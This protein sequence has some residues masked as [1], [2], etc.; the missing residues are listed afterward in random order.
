M[1]QINQVTHSDANNSNFRRDVAL[2]ITAGVLFMQTCSYS[3][4]W[5][6]PILTYIIA[7]VG[8]FA[9]IHRHSKGTI[10]QLWYYVINALGCT[11]LVAALWFSGKMATMF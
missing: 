6:L 2:C 10:N 3:S 9:T 8:L 11:G 7:T 5:F 1:N 4:G